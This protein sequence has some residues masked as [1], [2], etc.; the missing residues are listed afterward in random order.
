[1]NGFFIISYI[2][3]MIFIFIGMGWLLVCGSRN[4]V[5]YSFIVIELLLLAWLISQLILL[6][7]DNPLQRVIGCCISSFVVCVTGSAWLYFALNF[8][9]HKITPVLYGIILGLPLIHLLLFSTNNIHLL[10]YT[11]KTF[12]GRGIFFW[13]NF[14]Y[15][16]IA[17]VSGLWVIWKSCLKYKLYKKTV[18]FLLTLAVAAPLL[19][20][21][22][23]VFSMIKSEMDLTPV[24]FTLS[25]LIILMAVRNFG[26]LNINGMALDRIFGEIGQGIIVCNMNGNISYQNRLGEEYSAFIENREENEWEVCHKD[27][28]Y[29]IKRLVHRN[30]LKTPVAYTL[31]I[32]DVT[33][34]YELIR[35]NNELNAANAALQAERERNI[36]A[37]QLHDTIG[38]TLTKINTLARMSRIECKDY[39]QQIEE[40]A[41][42]GISELRETVNVMKKNKPLLMTDALKS[43]TKTHGINVNLT[44][45]GEDSPNYMNLT[46]TVYQSAREAL[47]NALRYGDAENMDII[48]RFKADRVEVFIFDDGKGCKEIKYGNG[49]KGIEE[50]IKASK[51]SVTFSS[52][53]GEGFRIKIKLPMEV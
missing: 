11:T 24:A 29:S 3:S 14:F 37:Q 44:V 40:I 43:L 6:F 48:V 8:A 23:Y 41:T 4:K 13:T 33:R 39:S 7:A 35:K 25:S 9:K 2:L 18:S 53:E 49:L 45:Q 34:F 28:I 50:R 30:S 38:H 42:E 52:V 22:V 19:L 15:T 12:S 31:V 21:W 27:S 1:M 46:D 5:T 20:N 16:H 32:S 47:T 51:G 36:I 26:F 17:M 10:F